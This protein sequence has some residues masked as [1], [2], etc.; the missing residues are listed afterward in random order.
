MAYAT[1]TDIERQIDSADLIQLTDDERTGDVDTDVV[2]RA[3]ADADEEIDGYIGS[4]LAVPL[5]PVPGI[6]RKMSVDIAIYNLYSRRRAEIPEAR[7]DRY[8]D[9][10]RFIRSVAKGEISMGA[11]DP[12]GNPPTAS[13]ISSSGCDQVFTASKMERF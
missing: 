1:L 6:I 7:R 11:N 2:T 12:G 9:A 10:I 5:D 13:G 3:I 4:R 8:N